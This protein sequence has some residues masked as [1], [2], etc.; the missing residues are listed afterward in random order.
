MKKRLSVLTVLFVAMCCSFVF[1]GCSDSKNQNSTET[2]KTTPTLTISD[3]SKTYDGE[4]VVASY[5]TDSDGSVTVLYKISDDDD[6]T[7][8]ASAPTGAGTYIIKVAVAETDNYYAVSD[9][10]SFEI[11]KA[12]PSAESYTLPTGL[13]LISGQTLS[14]I[15]LSTYGLTWSDENTVVTESGNYYATFTPSDTANYEIITDIEVE[16]TVI[17]NLTDVPTLSASFAYDGTEKAIDTSD[18]TDFDG[19]VMEIVAD[20]STISATDAGTYYIVIALKDGYA[21]SDYTTTDL[22]LSWSI[23]GIEVNEPTVTN[24]SFT[25]DGTEHQITIDYDSDYITQ[26]GTVSATDAG[27]YTVIFSL[28]DKT[29][30]YVWASDN[31]YVDLSYSWKI[32]KKKITVPTVADTSFIY[33]GNEHQIIID[34]DSD[35]ITQSGT[36]SATAKGSYTV[37]YA[38]N[39]KSNYI[40]QDGTTADKAYTWTISS[41]QIKIPTLSASFE[42][43]GNVKII[44]TSDI[45]DFDSDTMEMVADSST[46]SATDAGTYYIVIALKDSTNYEWSDG[47]TETKTLSWTIVGNTYDFTLTY[48][49]GTENCYDISYDSSTGEYT[50]NFG[51]IAAETKY[52]LSGELSGNIVI[53]VDQTETYKFYLVLSGATIT[54]AYNSPIFINSASKVIINAD[55]GTTNTITDNRAIIGD[56]STQKSAAIYSAVD[57][58][59]SGK[60]TL[61]IISA[62]NNGVHTK[63]DLEV[64][65]QTLTVT[66]VDNALKGNDEVSI[67]SGTITLIATDGDGIKTS[68]NALSSKGNQKGSVIISGGTVTIYA[69]SDGI[70][71][72]YDVTISGDSTIVDIY[73]TSEYAGSKVTSVSSV[74]SGTYYIMANSSYTYTYSIRY[75]TSS[76]YTMVNADTEAAKTSSGYKYFAVDTVAGATSF[77]IY[78]YSSS[79]TQG[80]L[81]GYYA[82]SSSKTLSTKYDTLKTTVSSSSV[83]SSWTLYETSSSSNSDKLVYSAKGIKADNEITISGGTITV[84]AYDDAIHANADEI[85]ESTNAYGTGNVTLSG[86]TVTVKSHDDGVH[87]D[88]TL[89][90]NGATVTVT[91]SY[92]GLEGNTVSIESGTATVTASDDGVNAQSAINVSGGRLDVTVSPS[93]DTD[94]I[95]SNGTITISGGIVIT[96]GPNSQTMSPLDADGAINIEG[97]TVIIIGYAPNSSSSGGQSGPGGQRNPFGG[98]GMTGGTLT[99]SSSLTKTQSSSAGLSKGSHTVTI[100]ST[101][102]SYTNTYTYSGYT[103]VYGSGSATIK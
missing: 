9:T 66:C 40:W 25:Y 98:G 31:S 78:V 96:R 82:K 64:K 44:A 29:G 62:N 63:D 61:N 11:S 94:G 34:Y 27:T 14:T 10:K 23:T 7:Y 59:L 88:G 74:V 12:V 97:G 43:D 69:A 79:Q 45:T 41:E 90:I 32:S 77:E 38:L 91:E 17:S 24:T 70:D 65:N 42:Y 93:G 53:D 86:G 8:V 101:T 51:T 33:D 19:D 18:I 84:Y 4:E 102:I 71:A 85:I 2:T 95:D 13:A 76:G 99:V 81:S 15:D 58:N 21:W 55:S 5:T 100:G 68:N 60:G 103:T 56:E 48:V 54:S 72:A 52:T 47:T 75:K 35:Y 67:E 6:S 80:S 28:P 87:A 49:S 83:S 26:S 1:N 30:N 92:E 20:G 16:I 37:T 73:T 36:V 22:T 89:T 39:D 46:I 57:L 3:L 50:I